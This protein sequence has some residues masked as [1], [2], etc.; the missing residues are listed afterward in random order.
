MGEARRWLG[1]PGGGGAELNPARGEGVLADR[2]GD[3][4]TLGLGAEAKGAGAGRP[5][6]VGVVPAPAAGAA[7]RGVVQAQRLAVC[8]GDWQ[9]LVAQLQR[10]NQGVVDPRRAAALGSDVV[11]CPELGKALAADRELANQLVEPGIVDL[12]ADQ[13]P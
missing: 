8:V 9:L 7:S 3:G 2:R 5:G 10:P 12:G 13:R 6:G 4:D 1:N 11:P